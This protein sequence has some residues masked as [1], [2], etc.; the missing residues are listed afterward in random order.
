[1]PCSRQ[2]DSCVNRVDSANLS[3]Y[4]GAS[5]EVSSTLSFASD[6]VP[7]LMLARSKWDLMK[8]R[9]VLPV[10]YA[11]M[12]VGASVWTLAH[13]MQLPSGER[14][15]TVFGVWTVLFAMPWDVW[16]LDL[17]DAI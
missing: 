1:M 14:V 16:A 6:F 3:F 9:L 13:P 11:A 7:I 8:A 17:S 10:T 2:P 4:R 12:F 15:R 5:D